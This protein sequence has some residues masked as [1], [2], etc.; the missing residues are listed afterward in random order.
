MPALVVFV[1]GYT[2]ILA[3]LLLSPIIR[4]I[5]YALC[6][7]KQ[8]PGRTC[9]LP[10]VRWKGYC[11]RVINPHLSIEAWATLFQEEFHEQTAA[12]PDTSSCHYLERLW[13]QH[14]AVYR[15]A[16]QGELGGSPEPVSAAG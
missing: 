13:L 15:R 14:L 5:C 4:P 6:P 9:V 7:R 1:A 12:V 3:F 2:S 8:R 10:E 16:D 11:N